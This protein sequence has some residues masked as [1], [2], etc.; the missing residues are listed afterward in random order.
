MHRGKRF[1][2]NMATAVITAMAGAGLA[3]A[4]SYDLSAGGSVA[5][6]GSLFQTGVIQ[7]AGTGIYDPFVRIQMNGTEQG[8]NTSGRPVAFN[9]LTDPNFTRSLLLTDVSIKTLD[10]IDY[11]EFVLDINES[12]S[13]TGRLLSL[14]QMKVFLSPTG[15]STTSNISLLGT[16]VYDLDAGGDNWIKLNASL[17]GPGSGTSDMFAYIPNSF[18]IGS[19]PYVTLYSQFGTN[20][21]SDAGFEEWSVQTGGGA[22]APVPEPTSMLLLGSGVAA[23]GAWRRKQIAAAQ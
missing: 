16:M 20:F 21:A 9:E 4:D 18:F 7:P 6:N 3:G 1:I 19:N 22:A 15:S 5:I 8:Y 11:R 13:S 17:N 23:F 12:G 2:F 14:D 10:G